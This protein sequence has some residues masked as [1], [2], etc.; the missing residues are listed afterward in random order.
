M[1]ITEP[2]DRAGTPELQFARQLYNSCRELFGDDHPQTRLLLDYLL[3]LEDG[4]GRQAITGSR[5]NTASIE[6][7]TTGMEYRL[8]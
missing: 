7:K 3:G 6:P 2:D 8:C 4:E 5:Y 1:P